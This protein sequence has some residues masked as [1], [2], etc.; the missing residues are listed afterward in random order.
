MKHWTVCS[1]QLCDV[2]YFACSCTHMRVHVHAQ[3]YV[4]ASKLE[5]DALGRGSQLDVEIMELARLGR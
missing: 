4:Y 3:V 2:D 1:A 5:F